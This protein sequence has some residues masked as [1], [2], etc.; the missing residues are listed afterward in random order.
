MAYRLIYSA[1][2]HSAA[3]AAAQAASLGSRRN[4]YLTHWRDTALGASFPKNI[5]LYRDGVAK[6]TGTLAS[7]PISTIGTD[8]AFAISAASQV[9]IAAADIDSG[10]WELRI[11]HPTD[12]SKFFGCAITRGGGDQAGSLNADLADG[13]AVAIGALVFRASPLL[14][15]GSTTTS[16]VQTSN[17]V[18]SAS[19]SS[20][21]LTLANQPTPGN[22]IVVDFAFSGNAGTTAFDPATLASSERRIWFDP[23]DLS[24]LKQD[25]AGSVAVTA[26]GQT[27][28]RWNNKGSLGG[29]LSNSTGWPLVANASGG[30]ELDANNGKSNG[31]AGGSVFESSGFSWGDVLPAATGGEIN[32]AFRADTAYDPGS[33][34]YWYSRNVW[35]AGDGH[36]GLSM[37]SSTSARAYHDDGTAEAVTLTHAQGTYELGTWV[38]D[39]GNLKANISTGSTLSAGVS[40][41]NTSG[42][43]SEAF[44]LG[45]PWHLGS[46][47]W[48]LFQGRVGAIIGGTVLSSDNRTSVKGYLSGSTNA[49]VPAGAITVTDNSGRAHSYVM[50]EDLVSADGTMRAVRAV[51]H[52]ANSKDGASSTVDFV[53][54]VTL[55]GPGYAAAGVAYEVA[56]LQ[57]AASLDASVSREVEATGTSGTLTMS[58]GSIAQ[59]V[60][61]CSSVFVKN[62][63]SALNLNT[64]SGY[65]S[66]AVAQ[67]GTALGMRASLRAIADGAAQTVT[68][69]WDSGSAGR[70]LGVLTA[71]RTGVNTDPLPGNAGSG[72]TSTTGIAL[73]VADIQSDIQLQSV[74]EHDYPP[75]VVPT[76]YDWFLGWRGADTNDDGITQDLASPNPPSGF[77]AQVGW[78]EFFTDRANA[79]GTHNWGI[80]IQRMVTLD[81]RN[82]TWAI[83]RSITQAQELGGFRV[84]SYNP[85][86]SGAITTRVNASGRWE[87]FMPNEGGIFHFWEEPRSQI[88]GA[89]ASDRAC[90]VIARLIVWN[91]A[92]TDDRANARVTCHAGIDYWRTTSAPFL[93]DYSNNS[94]M[95]IGR[96]RAFATDG[97]SKAFTITADCRGSTNATALRNALISLG[98]V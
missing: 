56:G 18:S 72:G 64:P 59:P 27:V 12:S 49:S 66:I 42:T 13:D 63:D 89:G 30:Y 50:P 16:T 20:L 17:V 48:P 53:V 2:E 80:E 75:A 3:W 1:A 11:E 55:P 76:G 23:N 28:K 78:G 33:S 82:G 74:Q 21:T 87:I 46:G 60:L 57:G 69:T 41:G 10:Y 52:T 45:G 97:T 15:T 86:T 38:R 25:T 88:N 93:Q 65:S 6:W 4:I 77:S 35:M 22:K 84:I 40:T 51:L 43:T 9:T 7:M 81:L 54:T 67:D 37:F 98:V 58:T 62:T 32:V 14:D 61:A 90:V 71:F 47:T 26:A 34:D 70:A 29:Y 19:A 39:G 44:S 31:T 95:G 5:K 8:I 68:Q 24:T 36:A 73:S 85:Q 96:A 91:P 92:A 83:I 94:D 79:P